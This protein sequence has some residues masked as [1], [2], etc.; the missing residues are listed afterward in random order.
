MKNGTCEAEVGGSC[1][2]AVEEVYD[3]DT[4]EYVPEHSYGCLREEGNYAL[5]Y[6]KWKFSMYIRMSTM[7]PKLFG[8]QIWWYQTFL[9][10]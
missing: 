2:Q 3:P 9:L 4:N 10:T 6:N 7:K 5:S 8:I 1:F